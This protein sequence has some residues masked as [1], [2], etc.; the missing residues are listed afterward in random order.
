ME[1]SRDGFLPILDPNDIVQ[2][3]TLPFQNLFPYPLAP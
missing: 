1:F 2:M 3:E